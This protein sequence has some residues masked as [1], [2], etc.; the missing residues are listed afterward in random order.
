[1]AWDD[2]EARIPARIQV[3]QGTI[4]LT[5][6]G[7]ANV[8]RVNLSLRSE[9]A[10]AL[11]WKGGESVGLQIGSGEHAG[12][13]RIVRGSARAIAQ[14]RESRHGVIR[15]MFGVVP[16]LGDEEREAT[17]CDASKID[18]DTV[19]VILPDWSA[20]AHESVDEDQVL[21][22]PLHPRSSA[23]AKAKAPAPGAPL[24]APAA[25]PSVMSPAAPSKP[26]AP[27]GAKVLTLQGVTLDLNEENESISHAGKT[28]DITQRQA[29]FFDALLVGMPAPIDRAFLRKRIFAERANTPQSDVQLDLIAR[30]AKAIAASIGLEVVVTKGVG[31]GLRKS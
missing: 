5:R 12:R 20:I 30:D 19:E 9:L 22:I 11:G 14:V 17:P 13:M 2:V 26:V 3:K 10:A 28:M 7:K 29:V 31:I 23:P 25:K 27:K 18:D 16:A 24:A 15:F 6:R 1:M 4:S 8:V 21:T